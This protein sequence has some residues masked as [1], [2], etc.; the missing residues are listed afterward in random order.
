MD[1]NCR[2]TLWPQGAN[3]QDDVMPSAIAT[4]SLS[5]AGPT[6]ITGRANDTLM[7]LRERIKS[8]GHVQR[9][10]QEIPARGPGRGQQAHEE[11]NMPA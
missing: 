6:S 11:D 1:I 2:I 8:L 5:R 3:F 7:I 4:V 9:V 10:S